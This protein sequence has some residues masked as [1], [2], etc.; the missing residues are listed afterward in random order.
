MS[1]VLLTFSDTNLVSMLLV[2]QSQAPHSRHVLP[3]KRREQLFHILYGLAMTERATLSRD[4][5]N[6]LV[7]N[8]MASPGRALY[9][10]GL[11][12]F[13]NICNTGVREDRI[14]IV[15][16]TILCE[17]SDQPLSV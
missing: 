16:A 10:F 17:K 5:Y 1:L 4:T 13:A 12:C 8:L 14:T 6:N 15:C 7:R 11:C 9:Y 3:C 2:V